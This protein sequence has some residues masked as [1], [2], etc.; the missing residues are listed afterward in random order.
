MKVSLISVFVTLM[1]YRD[2][3]LSESDC[4]LFSNSNN[5]GLTETFCKDE[6]RERKKHGMRIYKY[7]K[8]GVVKN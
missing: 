6:Q 5:L 7:K 3:C 8:L 1:S 4:V 2:Y